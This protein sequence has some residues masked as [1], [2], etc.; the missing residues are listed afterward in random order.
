MLFVLILFIILLLYQLRFLLLFRNK[1]YNQPQSAAQPPVTVILYTS[2]CEETLPQTLEILL[3][4]NYPNYEIIVVNNDRNNETEDLLK[5]IAAEHTNFYHTYIPHDVRYLSRKKLAL[6]L[7]IKAAHHP[8][9]LFTEPDCSPVSENWIASMMQAYRNDTDIVLGYCVYPFHNTLTQKL[10]A[11]ANLTDGMSYLSSALSSS[12]YRGDGRNLSYRKTLFAKAQGFRNHLDLLAGEDDLFIYDTA[13]KGNIRICL[14]SDSFT[15]NLRPISW[16]HWKQKELQR[17]VSAHQFHGMR[18]F[19]LRIEPL[20]LAL[21][22]LSIFGGTALFF[23]TG[24]WLPIAAW[25]IS[26]LLYYLGKTLL[27]HKAARL[28]QSPFIGWNLPFFDIF[29]VSHFLVSAIRYPFLK[30][31]HYIFRVSRKQNLKK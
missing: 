1:N 31:S 13:Q 20:F 2:D 25:G 30:K 18:P 26:Y 4:Q 5:R 17:S 14:S 24:D 16:K 21:F 19:L 23:L 11:Y 6:T 8:Y 27:Y 9:L 15:R 7:G 29:L 22:L 3:K 28:L 10:I 12:F